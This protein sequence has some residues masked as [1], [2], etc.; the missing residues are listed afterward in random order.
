MG[1]CSVFI[2]RKGKLKFKM[3]KTQHKRSDQE[4][5]IKL[6]ER[7]QKYKEEKNKINLKIS[8]KK[9]GSTKPKDKSLNTVK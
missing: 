4:N 8:I 2:M 7:K 6:E 1:K 3:L 5:K 9:K